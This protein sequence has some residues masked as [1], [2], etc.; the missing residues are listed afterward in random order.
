MLVLCYEQTDRQI[1]WYMLLFCTASSREDTAF[2]DHRLTVA[3][4]AALGAVSF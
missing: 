3:I 2:V 4:S 1:D